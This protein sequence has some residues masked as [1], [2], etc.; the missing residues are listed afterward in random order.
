[1]S[2][3]SLIVTV[4]DLADSPI[5]DVAAD[6][7]AT[8]LYEGKKGKHLRLVQISKADVRQYATLL[9]HGGVA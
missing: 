9:G 1:M 5:T 7:D 3:D 6:E 2:N 4:E 8:F